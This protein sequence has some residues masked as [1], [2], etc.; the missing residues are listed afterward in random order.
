[1]QKFKLC[2]W[3]TCTCISYVSAK[4]SISSCHRDLVCK[5]W[6]CTSDVVHVSE[7]CRTAVMSEKQDPSKQCW[8]QTPALLFS[9]TYPWLLESLGNVLLLVPHVPLGLRLGLHNAGN[10]ANQETQEGC[11]I[12]YFIFLNRCKRY[13]IGN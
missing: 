7:T 1:M 11:D 4:F 8:W 6:L 10:P 13:F 3:Y 2:M 12:F 5:S 9:H